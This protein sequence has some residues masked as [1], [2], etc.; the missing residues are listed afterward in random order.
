MENLELYKDI[1]TIAKPFVDPLISTILKPKLESL[2]KWLK[3]RSIDNDL[4]D[5]FYKNKFEEYLYRTY[6]NSFY[7]NTIVFPNQKIRISEIFYPITL[8]CTKDYKRYKV[9]KINSDFFENNSRILISDYAGMGKST[10]SR[11]LVNRCID[12]NIGIPVFIELRQI[13][14]QNTIID[15]LF[16]Q[17]NPIENDVDKDFILKV[18][19]RGDFV[20]IFDGFDEIPMKNQEFVIKNTRSFISKTSNN[21]FII[22]SRPEAALSSFGDFQN[23]F[24]D[25]LK[26]EESFEIIDKYDR[27]S[28]T[29]IAENLKSDINERVAQ[30]EEFLTN[31]FLISLLYKSYSYNKDIPSKRVTF[32]DEVYCALFKAHDLSKN[33]YKRFKKSKLDI[34]DFR[35]ILRDLAFNTSKYRLVEYSEQELLRFISDSKANSV[36]IDFKERDFLDDLL[37]SVPIII[38]DGNKIKWAHK[39]IQDYFA[40]EFICFH[41]QKEKILNKIFTTK[42]ETFLNVLILIQELD[43]SIFRKTILLKLLKNYVNYYN[44]SYRKFKFNNDVHLRKLMTYGLDV[45]FLKMSKREGDT[46]TAARKIVWKK[47][48]SLKGVNFHTRLMLPYN[49]FS[50]SVFDFNRKLIDLLFTVQPEIYYKSFDV[51]FF[52][53]YDILKKIDVPERL[54][55]SL[56]N[57]LNT[58]KNFKIVNFWVYDNIRFMGYK[59]KQIC[60]LDIKKCINKIETI[61]AEIKSDKSF[62]ILEGL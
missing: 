14:S 23:F 2:S 12:Q 21:K 54:T 33:G 38:R 48:S 39:S 31:P 4:I 18:F 44:R 36:G 20:I 25:P 61:E 16:N 11:Y 26:K 51:D 17:L 35:I 19:S 5:D 13:N 58:N 27:I 24:I 3:K 45:F 59:S 30:V 52:M 60:I 37:L 41:S 53:N 28:K 47:Y 46:Y 50:L 10:L 55:D 15:E 29:K 49:F 22:T 8:V 1:Y 9:N 6:Q 40:A 56:T 7:V 42:N 62:D 43:V 57:N 34:Q 32:Y